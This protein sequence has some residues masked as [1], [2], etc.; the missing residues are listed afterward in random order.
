MKATKN[1]RA[2]KKNKN[3]RLK[4]REDR[5]IQEIL[6]IE[7]LETRMLLSGVGTGLGKKKV[8][9][10]DSVGDKVTVAINEAG[11]IKG[12]LAPTFDIT[13][14]G[15]ALD[16][17]NVQSIAIHGDAHTAL[18]VLVQSQRYTGGTIV[19]GGKVIY[20]QYWT[21]GITEIGSIS[22]TNTGAKSGS[23]LSYGTGTD[24]RGVSV[25]GGF[26]DNV[27]ITG[28]LTGL[29]ED[30]GNVKFISGVDTTQVGQIHFGNVAV[31]GNLGVLTLNGVSNQAFTNDLSG[32]VTVGGT[33]GILNAKFSN[34]LAP[35]SANAIGSV[36]VQDVKANIT[37]TTSIG[38][39]VATDLYAQIKGATIGSVSLVSTTGTSAGGDH[40]LRGNLVGTVTAATSLGSVSVVGSLSGTVNVTNGN[41]GDV[42]LG[43]TSFTGN[44]LASGSIGNVL[45]SQTG[46]TVFQ[47]HLIAGTS[48]GNV[49]AGSF[50]NADIE[51]GT[52]IGTITSLNDISQ[53]NGINHTTI[54]AHNGGIAGVN[55]AGT[56]QNSTFTATGAIGAVNVSQGGINNN[57]FTGSSIGN[58]ASVQDIEDNTLVSTGAIGSL[59]VTNGGIYENTLT[60]ASIGALTSTGGNGSISDNLIQSTTGGIGAISAATGSITGNTIKSATTVG[61][62]TSSLN[63]VS[64]NQIFSASV[65]NLSG[66]TGV[67]D[68]NINASAGAVGNLTAANGDVNDN[69][70]NATGAIGNTAAGGQIYSNQFNGASIGSLAAVNGD[71]SE[72]TLVSKVGGIGA[73][74]SQNSAVSYNQITSA[75]AVGDVAAG[76]NI[77]N[78]VI[79]AAGAVGNFTAT[80]DS[81]ATNLITGA[82]VGNLTAK[83]DI[84]NN[85]VNST[86]GNIGNLT[87]ANGS[88]YGDRI[89]ASGSIGNLSANLTVTDSDAIYNSTFTAIAGSIGNITAN[90][91]NGDGIDQIT[92]RAAT[93]IGNVS[94]NVY[95]NGVAIDQ[96]TFDVTGAGN[97]GNIS[98]TAIND[99]AIY[100]TT[101]ET[102]GGNIGNV[103][104]TSNVGYGIDASEIHT[105]AGNIGNVTGI[106]DVTDGIHNTKIAADG[107]NIGNVT[108][109][110]HGTAGG[111]TGDGLNNVTIAAGAGLHGTGRLGVVLG[112][113]AHGHGIDGGLITAGS[114][115]IAG[116]SGVETGTQD[117]S[118]WNGIQNAQVFTTGTIDAISGTSAG[119]NGIVNSKFSADVN[120]AAIS[121]STTS[122]NKSAYGIGGDI[123]RA[124]G[125]IGAITASTAITG[126]NAING[127]A[128]A[129]TTAK[130]TLGGT[131]DWVTAT[132]P[133]VVAKDTIF[134]A[135]GNIAS[136]T[137]TQGNITGTVFMAGYDIGS[138]LRI[139][140][141]GSSG[142]GMDFVAQPD[143][144]GNI[145]GNSIGAITVSKGSL[146]HSSFTASVVTTDNTFGNGDDMLN[147]VDGKSNGSSIGTITVSGIIDHVVVAADTLNAS[148]VT[149]GQLSSLYLHAYRG[150][151][152]NITAASNIDGASTVVN[153][154]F[155]A[156]GA[157]GTIGNVSVSQLAA[158]G[159]DAI[160]GSYFAAGASIGNVTAS[161]NGGSGLVNANAIETS[162]FLAKTG[163][164]D[165][166]AS[167]DNVN[168]LN[169]FSG[170]THSLFDANVDSNTSGAIGTVFAITNGAGAG[171]GIDNSGFYAAAGIGVNGHTLSAS[172]NGVTYT[173]TGGVTGTV[174]AETGNSGL[175]NVTLAG[176]LDPFSPTYTSGTPVYGSLGSLGH[177]TNV[178]GSVGNV[179]GTTAGL[180]NGQDTVFIAGQTIGTIIG[181]A[182]NASATTEQFGLTHVNAVAQQ[183]IGDVTG[184]VNGL[185]VAGK[186]NAGI[187]NSKFY[188]GSTSSAVEPGG[189]GASI[190]NIS[191]TAGDLAHMTVGNQVGIRSSF[192]EAGSNSYVSDVG[193]IGTITANAFATGGINTI[194]KAT[195]I[196]ETNFLANGYP[197][198]TGISTAA[199]AKIGAINVTATAGGI[200]GAYA[201]GIYG[202]EVYAG[203][204]LALGAST[205]G[206]LT[207]NATATGSGGVKTQVTA[208]GLTGGADIESYGLGYVGN[209]ASV[210]AVKVTAQATTTD[211]TT[212]KAHAID[213]AK[214]I[215][216]IGDQAQGSIASIKATANATSAFAD[217]EAYGT[218]KFV[219]N[220]GVGAGTETGVIG[221]VTGT[222]TA[223]AYTAARAGGLMGGTVVYAGYGTTGTG[224]IGAITGTANATAFGVNNVTAI[225]NGIFGAD[226]NAQAGTGSI[227]DITGSGIAAATTSGT[228][229]TAGATGYGISSS[230]FTAG[231]VANGVGTIGVTNGTIS[232]IGTATAKNTNL[233]VGGAATALG[234]GIGGVGSVTF[235]AGQTTGTIAKNGI[236][237]TG[238]VTASGFEAF[239]LGAGIGSVSGVAEFDAANNTTGISG[240][241]G[242]I[243]GSTTVGA[244]AGGTGGKGAIAVGFGIFGLTVDSGMGTAVGSTGTVNLITG[245]ANVTSSATGTSKTDIA[246]AGGSGVAGALV[247]AGS[248]GTGNILGITGSVPILTATAAGTDAAAGVGGV[249]LVEVTLNAGNLVQ[250][251]VGQIG[252]IIGTVGSLTTQA[253]AT[254]NVGNAG[255]I[256]GGID[257]LQVQS[258]QAGGDG[259]SAV[260]NIKGQSWTTATAGG[261]GNDVVVYG[262]GITNVSRGTVVNVVSGAGK[263]IGTIGDITGTAIATGSAPGGKANVEVGAIYNDVG[264]GH[265]FTFTA[266]G[267]A[268]GGQGT[269]AA[270]VGGTGI[271]AT[272]SATASGLSDVNASSRGIDTVA[273]AADDLGLNG[274]I[275]AINAT[276][277][278]SATSTSTTL[279][280]NTTASATSITDSTFLAGTAIGKVN[281][282]GVI[283]N[284]TTNATATALM[285]SDN[286]SAIAYG[287]DTVA[288]TAGGGTDTLSIGKI[289]DISGTAA[290]TATATTGGTTAGSVVATATGIHSIKANAIGFVNS[291]GS[292]A[293]KG[294]AIASTN[295]TGATATA[296]GTGID[297]SFVNALGSPIIIK[298]TE[299]D[300][301]TIGGTAGT[302][303]G[304]GSATATTDGAVGGLA[305]AN[306]SGISD[307][308]FNANGDISNLALN[309]ITG[310]FTGIANGASATSTGYGIDAVKIFSANTLTGVNG[311]VGTISGTAT[312][313]ANATGSTATNGTA[314]AMGGGIDLMLV[315]AGSGTV[316]GATGNVGD[317]TGAANVV[318]SATGTNAVNTATAMGGG[319]VA[320][321]VIS[322]AN[323]IGNIGNVKGT[324]DTLSATSAAIDNTGLT[325]SDGAGSDAYIAGGGI[326]GLNLAA[327]NISGNG[328]GVIGN[329]TGTVGSRGTHA[330]ATAS[331]GSAFAQVGG[332]VGGTFGVA[333]TAGNAAS[334]STTASSVGNITGTVFADATAGGS[335]IGVAGTAAVGGT[336]LS[337]YDGNNATAFSVAVY[338]GAAS[339]GVAS[340]GDIVGSATGVAS[341]VAGV[342]SASAMEGIYNHSAGVTFS[343]VGNA[344]GG[345]TVIGNTALT[346]GTNPD[347]TGITGNAFAIANGLTSSTAT[348]YG[349]DGVTVNADAGG[350]NGTIGVIN[351][352][353]SATAGSTG[354][355]ALVN[356]TTADAE[357]MY[358]SNTFNTFNAGTGTGAVVSVGSIGNIT[359]TATATA[360]ATGGDNATAYAGSNNGGATGDVFSVSGGQKAGSNGTIGT[361]IAG[362]VANPIAANATSAGGSADSEAWGPYDMTLNA[363]NGGLKGSVGNISAVTTATATAT[364]TALGDYAKALGY[365]ISGDLGG[366]GLTINAGTLGGAVASIGSIGN[367]TATTTAT[368]T[369]AG[370]YAVADSYGLDQDN[371]TVSGGTLAGASGTIGTLSGV[372]TSTA[373]STATGT[374]VGVSSADAYGIEYSHFHANSGGTN[375]IAFGAGLS[376]TG[377]ATATVTSAANDSY[378]NADG[379]QDSSFQAGHHQVAGNIGNINGTA[380]GSATTTSTTTPDNALTANV[381][382]SGIRQASFDAGDS[383]ALKGSGTIG[384]ITT[385]ATADATGTTGAFTQA[386]GTNETSFHAGGDGGVSSSIGD[387]KATIHAISMT[388]K[389]GADAN[390]YG[391]YRTHLTAEGL[392]GTIGTITVTGN[393]TITTTADVDAVLTGLAAY[394]S[395]GATTVVN[396]DT[397]EAYAYGISETTINA[398][399]GTALGVGTIGAINVGLGDTFNVESFNA[400]AGTVGAAIAEAYG[401]TGG[402]RL[403]AGSNAAGGT[404]NIGFAAVSTISVSASAI[405]PVMTGATKSTTKA[406]SIDKGLTIE[407]GVTNT[408]TGTGNIGDITV[409]AIADGDYY[410]TQTG[411]SSL[412]VGIASNIKAG[413]SVGG[414]QA[415]QGTIGNITVNVISSNDA[416]GL[417]AADGIIFTNITSGDS[418]GAG[419][420]AGTIGNITAN[421]TTDAHVNSI[422]DGI[423]FTNVNAATSIGT[424]TATSSGGTG[425]NAWPIGVSSF[426]ADA[427]SIGRIAA[428][429][430]GTAAIIGSSFTAYTNIA[431]GSFNSITGSI[432]TTGDGIVGVGTVTG[433]SFVAGFSIGTGGQN[434]NATAAVSIGDVHVSGFFTASDILSGVVAVGGTVGG[435]AGDAISGLG[436]SIGAIVIGLPTP[437]PATLGGGA[438]NWSHGIEAHSIGSVNWGLDV[439]GAIGTGAYNWGYDADGSGTAS[440]LDGNDVVVRHV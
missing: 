360:T 41:L 336:G 420:G 26:I 410:D 136:I 218:T 116:I 45:V 362:T 141:I 314:F 53:N 152:G 278:A 20:P 363:S 415:N 88:L 315:V 133:T 238:T 73:I 390:A 51:A 439:S 2:S 198:S 379:I 209:V 153:S 105:L 242:A 244:T 43:G 193:T 268:T 421:A 180:G 81:I 288:V 355:K 210:G 115:G 392:I 361:I 21:T 106:S 345:S 296:T 126:A 154:V 318:A 186:Y 254:D 194:V 246:L 352:T 113:T 185:G 176:N 59:T 407:A 131:N 94:A 159:A 33:L 357:A 203:S 354:G 240:L 263:G 416:G 413:V 316:A 414:L 402:S 302:I 348:A 353:V 52:S 13:L 364:G 370:D 320:T 294:T 233:A 324:V 1:V 150:G 173:A 227:D 54:A 293:G 120:I 167:V 191:G 10:F 418:D 199:G 189:L 298:N 77:S 307:T 69:I 269:I 40:G 162:Y 49:T 166:T 230:T 18:S 183:K 9:F 44:I 102:V 430:S 351:A 275:G 103:S 437:G 262:G 83:G 330:S 92:F 332:I 266:G 411:T 188:A 388:T 286:G 86:A 70:V 436:G 419:A 151:L 174:L 135:G 17:A 184:S 284:I 140:G 149:A 87:A 304:I 121:G 290:G 277:T 232:A 252:N 300:P 4:K 161:T 216:G 412:A 213:N 110:S 144:A 341:A 373:T 201:R 409:K 179:T 256:V 137:A 321:T 346:G 289:G 157:L 34:V 248:S 255:S 331:A 31:T 319:I 329:I 251:G 369:A 287:F 5:A 172:E 99:T 91:V 61:D 75:G 376:I 440:N 119:G 164:G 236:T 7:A 147:V 30:I 104:G 98:A 399:N 211:I 282:V 202:G 382:V 47:G 310:Q 403:V 79:G 158:G 117:G 400:G 130:V 178:A 16:H 96:S 220:A 393:G 62:L 82:S 234:A 192:F 42:S 405:D 271:T 408:A 100:F 200:D 387:V 237:A 72:N 265:A 401:I 8:V 261:T 349:I 328:Y 64:G 389:G 371:F 394:A 125:N 204:N 50:D 84:S 39:V 28:N 187:D 145:V 60:G 317:I 434:P 35:I 219:V 221:P 368:A 101:I 423:V 118:G 182:S 367:V 146:T 206:D 250:T 365:G 279:V 292:I 398:A 334:T 375:N 306:G 48:V 123:F 66:F 23:V 239:A 14:D 260:G 247:N 109:I 347:T 344:V 280:N 168:G 27:N 71:V 207:I 143:A 431:S 6:Q 197:N 267:T 383:N 274:T 3:L 417:N 299:V 55:S 426:N 11:A 196:Y 124:G 127:S 97:I 93:G 425:V 80:A 229:S 175:L 325:N 38:S 283:G 270:A 112:Q 356:T 223:V 231:N 129:N 285:G 432:I 295:G 404:G 435:N 222:G 386:K 128:T 171:N 281:S 243:S 32:T 253:T 308:T 155:E 333:V 258:G 156:E 89:V 397:A 78:N 276:T 65:G 350:L 259:T 170:I 90:T 303:S 374:K 58:F 19:D 372:A 205:I 122:Q 163:I 366:P 85:V 114:G 377:S 438:V 342:A 22:N 245:T 301:S 74:S 427:G 327:G 323:G 212:A 217:A 208:Y 381:W 15:G 165:I 395:T 338:T 312:V 340:I 322:G 95:G 76:T 424:I 67:N 428:T 224:T 24:L 335:G 385:L 339:T 142:P 148:S 12:H 313:T 225:A 241:V 264:K 406:I 297:P 107:S 68:N 235:T 273:V 29:A 138:D 169:A 25:N 422:S 181:T 134:S 305:T 190:G 343:V 160:S 139:D 384:N 326:D 111:A 57:S 226:V 359:Y 228:G 272:G 429:T 177:V 56:I 46:H 337:D 132:V 433:S 37:A 380:I 378:V 358:D 108:G 311:T 195:G 309:G 36:S 215:A 63:S 391:L 257:G 396:A 291:V 214:I 249:G